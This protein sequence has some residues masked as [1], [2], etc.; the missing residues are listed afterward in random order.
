MPSSLKRRPDVTPSGNLGE[1]RIH[2]VIGYQVAQAA[3]AT[4][5]IFD[6]EVGGEMD[7]RPVEYTVLALIEDN[8]GVTGARLARALA[9]T[10][11]NIVMWLS[12]LEKRALVRRETGSTDRRTQTLRTTAAGSKLAARATQRLVQRERETL[13]LSEAERAMLI[14]LLSKVARAREPRSA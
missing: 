1:T 5:G 6:R 11:P 3:I 2:D 12:R 7:L 10:A 8:P 4:L 14:E 13:H 9:V